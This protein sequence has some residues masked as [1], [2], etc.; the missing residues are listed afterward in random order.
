[1]RSSADLIVSTSDRI[2]SRRRESAAAFA[3]KRQR[4]QTAALLSAAVERERAALGISPTG[5]EQE[6]AETEAAEAQG[7]A[8]EADGLV[9]S[10]SDYSR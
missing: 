4:P 9:G 3:H 8:L 1:M 5:E 6:E 10:D 7:A 2:S